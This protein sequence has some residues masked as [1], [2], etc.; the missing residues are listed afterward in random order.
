MG[1]FL[2]D[3]LHAHRA[4]VLPHQITERVIDHGCGDRCAKPET[5]GEIRRHIVFTTTDMDCALFGLAHRHN[6]R[7]EA[8]NHCAEREKVEPT[9][10]GCHGRRN[11]QR[12]RLG[13]DGPGLRSTGMH[14][15]RH[16]PP[17]AGAR[18]SD[19]LPVARA[20]D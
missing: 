11:V 2:I 19:I 9:G 20:D 5:I 16:S 10:V 1:K 14:W 4:N 6:A 13:H 7:V 18:T 15:Q 17:N 3:A 8:V 12:E